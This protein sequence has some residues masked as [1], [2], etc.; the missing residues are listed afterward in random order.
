MVTCRYLVG[1]P[2]LGFVSLVSWLPVLAM[3]F[4]LTQTDFYQH[5]GA[6]LESSCEVRGRGVKPTPSVASCVS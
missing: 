4:L 3:L 5:D 6:T 1:Q 2:I